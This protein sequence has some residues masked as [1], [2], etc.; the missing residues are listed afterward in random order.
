MWLSWSFFS[1]FCKNVQDYS[2]WFRHACYLWCLTQHC[3]SG[4][5]LYWRT[6]EDS[7]GSPQRFNTS[8]SSTPSP[9]PCGLSGEKHS[10]ALFVESSRPTPSQ[11]NKVLGEWRIY[12]SLSCSSKTCGWILLDFCVKNR[13]HDEKTTMFS[14][15]KTTEA[16]V[17]GGMSSYECRHTCHVLF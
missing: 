7:P 16:Q 1:G 2:R 4:R 10:Q 5:A 15:H 3:K 12:H 17:V 14:F 6:S 9:D 11:V 8:F 13:L